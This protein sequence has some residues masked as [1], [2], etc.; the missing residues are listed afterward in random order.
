MDAH[1][2]LGL[3][4][5][6]EIGDDRAA[7]EAAVAAGNPLPSDVSLSSEEREAVE[8]LDFVYKHVAYALM[9][10]PRPQ[11]LS[12]LVDSPVGLAAFM[13][14]H[15]RDSLELISRSFA[16]QPEGLPRDDVLDNITLFWLTR[17]AISA[18]RLYWENTEAGIPF[19]GAKGVELPVAVSVFPDE[20]CTPPGAGRRRPTRTSSTTTG[21]PRAATSPR[22]SS[23]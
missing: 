11:S 6:H 23:P 3:L 1:Q 19:F 7:I 2:P 13:L 16:G 15:D 12:G 14:D 21:C 8:Q 20:L 5:P 10:G 17:S 22:G 18:A 9:M 4:H